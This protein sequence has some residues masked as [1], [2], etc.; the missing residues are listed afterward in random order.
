MINLLQRVSQASV[1]VGGDQIASIQ[2]GLLVLVGFEARDAASMSASSEGPLPHAI[3]QN[4]QRRLE[5]MADR[6]LSYRV[7]SDERDRMNL[8][9]MQ[10]GGAVLLVPQFTLAADT[11]K[12]LRPG[13]H[14]AAPP[15]QAKVLFD[16]YH[17][18]V[19]SRHPEVQQ[20]QFGADMQVSLVNSGPVTFWLQL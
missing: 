8:N 1:V 2:Q 20:G 6:L 9:V 15:E 19:K 5:K 18:A 14:T 11:S 7:F 10:V 4:T 16:H 12:G 17:A 3:D 13:F